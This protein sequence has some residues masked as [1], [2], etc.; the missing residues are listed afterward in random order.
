M[1]IEYIQLNSTS[2]NMRSTQYFGLAL[3]GLLPSSLGY[4]YDAPVT[5]ADG[6]V[7]GYR[8]LNSSTASNLTNWQS[9]AVWKGIPFAAST[10]GKNRWRAPQP[11]EPWN[12]TLEAKSFG[13]GCAQSSGGLTFGKVKRQMGSANTAATSEDCLTVNIWSP[14]LSSNDKLPV[15]VWSYGAGSTSS[16]DQF[17]GA[18]L[19]DKGLVF[20]TYN[21]RT[22]PFGWLA[23]PELSK[24]NPRNISGNY[25]L[26]DQIEVLKWVKMNIAAFGG[27]PD[28]ITTVGQSFGSGAVLHEINS[29]LAKGLIV[30]AI[31][32]SGIKDPYDPTYSGY[33]SNHVNF[34]YL[35]PFS[36]TYVKSLNVST[37]AQLRN[38]STAELLLGT[39]VNTFGVGFD[40]V[41]DGYAIPSTYAD[42]LK[43][44]PANDVPVLVG[45]NRDEDGVTYDA[46][47][48]VSEYK[49]DA[50][51][52]YSN[53]TYWTDVFLDLYPGTDNASATTAYK[54]QIRDQS[55][56]ST[57]LWANAWAKTAKSPVYTYEWDWSPPGDQGASHASEIPYV[58]NTLFADTTTAWRDSD[59]AIAAIMSTYWANF[60]KTGDPNNDGTKGSKRLA[61]FTSSEACKETTFNLG[62]VFEEVPLA[63][64]AQVK[65]ARDYFYNV[66]TQ[67]E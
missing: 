35:Y 54:A 23:L 51:S 45:N 25:G 53:N 67:P 41:Q 59:Y 65:A 7:Q 15:A 30:G 48:T 27:D 10:A 9:I 5:I 3:A 4:L 40:P 38:L 1:Q 36:E 31:A 63:S 16:D 26:Y 12:T 44:G 47:Y 28:H 2:R 64:P 52:Y 57:W 17:N 49:A 32:Q 14:A 6:K 33:G 34:S 61:K 66:T 60:I 46:N 62:T 58:L 37:V 13:P 20:V 29:P 56:I 39:G 19:A 24:E 55:R 8:A 50:L 22:G 21:Y 42:S 43:H 18:G 11:P